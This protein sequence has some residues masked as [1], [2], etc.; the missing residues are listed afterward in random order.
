MHACLTTNCTNLFKVLRSIFTV[1]KP[2]PVTGA[3]GET[4][5]FCGGLLAP[6]VVGLLIEKARNIFLSFAISSVIIF[7]IIHE[8]RRQ[9]SSDLSRSRRFY[10]TSPI[11]KNLLAVVHAVTGVFYWRLRFHAQIENYIPL[12][13]SL[14]VTTVGLIRT[15]DRLTDTSKRIPWVY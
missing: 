8:L 4:S 12:C 10:A 15:S 7:Q 2:K 13:S 6:S 5:L 3:A 9:L 1:F 11:Q 14:H